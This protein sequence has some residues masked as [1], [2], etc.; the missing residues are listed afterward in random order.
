LNLIRVMPAKGTEQICALR[1]RIIP[2]VVRAFVWARRAHS[3][4]RFRTKLRLAFEHGAP[5]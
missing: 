5:G 2:A 1:S 3:I 4:G